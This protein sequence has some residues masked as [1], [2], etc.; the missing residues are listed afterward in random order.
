[1]GPSTK[2]GLAASARLLE[3]AVEANPRNPLAVYVLG[4][5]YRR[6]GRAAA[7]RAQYIEGHEL[8]RRFGHVPAGPKAANAEAER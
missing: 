5:V 7:A 6:Q 4:H 1:M 3:L 2:A 8:Y